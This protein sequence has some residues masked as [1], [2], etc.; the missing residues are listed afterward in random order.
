MRR[1]PSEF[2]PYQLI[3][4]SHELTPEDIPIELPGRQDGQGEWLEQLVEEYLDARSYIVRRNIN[5]FDG[6]S[7]D[8]TTKTFEID[9]FAKNYK[10]GKQ[11]LI[12]CKDWHEEII[13]PSVIGRVC[14]LAE[15]CN[16]IPVIAHST[17]LST[18]A[19]QLAR[20]SQTLELP[21]TRILKNDCTRADFKPLPAYELVEEYGKL[22]NYFEISPIDPFDNEDMK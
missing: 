11:Y 8:P 2:R 13:R 19:E 10:T 15:I 16:S 6:L 4:D 7:P 22:R 5:L 12:Q 20:Y 9:V 21:L 3:K 17:I 1:T 14:T 18:K